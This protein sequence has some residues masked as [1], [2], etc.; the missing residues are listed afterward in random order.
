[1]HLEPGCEACR[2]SAVD[3]FRTGS[4]FTCDNC[5]QHAKEC[6]FSCHVPRQTST[7]PAQLSDK[8]WDLEQLS[9]KSNYTSSRQ[10]EADVTRIKSKRKRRTES[11]TAVK[12]LKS[13]SPVDASPPRGSLIPQLQSILSDLLSLIV[14]PSAADASQVDLSSLSPSSD[15]SASSLPITERAEVEKKYKEWKVTVSSLLEEALLPQSPLRRPSLESL[16]DLVQLGQALVDEY[17]D[18]LV[19]D[20]LTEISL[21]H[22]SVLWWTSGEDR[23]SILEECFRILCRI[24]NHKG[25]LYACEPKISEEHCIRYLPHY[26]HYLDL[27]F[28]FE[29][30]LMTPS[31]S[32]LHD[33]LSYLERVTRAL[34]YSEQNLVLDDG[35]KYVDEIVP[36]AMAVTSFQEQWHIHFPT[37]LLDFPTIIGTPSDDA[38]LSVSFGDSQFP[39][40][41]V[42][43]VVASMTRHALA[44]AILLSQEQRLHDSISQELRDITQRRLDEQLVYS[45]S[46]LSEAFKTSERCG[47][48]DSAILFFGN[49]A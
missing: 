3:C 21:K 23:K 1:M 49:E 26:Q 39:I 43:E 36:L 25:F 4:S 27:G 47:L 18:P 22:L 44:L 7:R 15:V 14:Y 29:L 6:I 46:Y 19:W 16:S 9:H 20:I 8:R 5:V 41:F 33:C 31:S 48:A 40:L 30:H 42:N 12:R 45:I 37:A 13:T 2:S 34:I 28:A 11:T 38:S 24:D 10:L 32:S 17:P 35:T